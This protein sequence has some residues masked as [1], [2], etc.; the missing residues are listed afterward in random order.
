MKIF[1]G[2]NDVKNAI[3][4]DETDTLMHVFEI[5]KFRNFH[6]MKIIKFVSKSSDEDN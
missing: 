4:Y 3:F 2:R 6:F 1:A 5:H